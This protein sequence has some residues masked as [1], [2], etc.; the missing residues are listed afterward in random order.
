MGDD[1]KFRSI[2]DRVLKGCPDT[3]KAPIAGPY[4]E[5]DLFRLVP[6]YFFRGF[7]KLK[8]PEDP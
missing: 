8:S 3:N 2:K 7:L 5:R 6:S 4:V 1:D